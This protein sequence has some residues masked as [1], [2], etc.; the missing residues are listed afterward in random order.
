[1]GGT[2]TPIGVEWQKA[3]T[4]LV[5]QGW[6]DGMQGWWDPCKLRTTFSTVSVAD[7]QELADI[8]IA[9]VLCGESG[10]QHIEIESNYQGLLIYGKNQL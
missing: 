8:N 9:R 1:V 7:T 2:P 3:R 4:I 5:E 6:H 10:L